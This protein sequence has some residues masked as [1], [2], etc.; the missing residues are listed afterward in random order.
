MH[1]L[2][3]VQCAVLLPQDGR[4][5]GIGSHR[6]Y[7]C[8]NRLFSNNPVRSRCPVFLPASSLQRACCQSRQLIFRQSIPYQNRCRVVLL[9]IRKSAPLSKIRIIGVPRSIQDH[10]PVQPRFH[11]DLR[12]VFQKTVVIQNNQRRIYH[13]T[14]G[15]PGDIFRR[16]VLKAPCCQHFRA[17]LFRCDDPSRCCFLVG[18]T[19]AYSRQSLQGVPRLV[20]FI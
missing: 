7:C 14:A 1:Q 3:K 5:L 4:G 17:D 15:N 10:G 16:R 19:A 2:V 12:T 13:K 20:D 9:Q 11:P 8:V 18:C 6:K